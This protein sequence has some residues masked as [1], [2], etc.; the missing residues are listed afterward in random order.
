MR[1]YEQNPLDSV[2][3]SIFNLPELTERKGVGIRSVTEESLPE[4][5][6]NCRGELHAVVV[7]V[8]RKSLRAPGREVHHRA[9]V[10]PHPDVVVLHVRHVRPPVQL[11]PPPQPG[12][13]LGLGCPHDSE[14]LA[15]VACTE[16]LQQPPLLSQEVPASNSRSCSP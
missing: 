16:D 4:T 6:V 10:S 8:G 12:C 7:R 15:L 9:G 3:S 1:T 2:T 11:R 5:R 13:D 14:G